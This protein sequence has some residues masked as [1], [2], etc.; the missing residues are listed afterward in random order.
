M[1]GLVP[2]IHVFF[3]P[4]PSTAFAVSVQG[5]GATSRTRRE[6]DMRV[7]TLAALLI[8]A[9]ALPADARVHPV[10][11]AVHGAAT[12]ASDVARGAVCLFTLGTRCR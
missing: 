5:A 6:T 11:G 4:E 12:A 3:T 2:G 1:P 7:L 8:A 10:K 9:F